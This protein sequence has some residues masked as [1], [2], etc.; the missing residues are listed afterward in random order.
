MFEKFSYVNNESYINNCLAL[1][2][3]YMESENVGAVISCFNV[4]IV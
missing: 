1:C 2:K 3:K 4:K